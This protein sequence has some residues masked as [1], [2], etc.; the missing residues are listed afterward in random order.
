MEEEEEEKGEANRGLTRF[1]GFYEAVAFSVNIILS[2]ASLARVPLSLHYPYD[3]RR[4]NV[5]VPLLFP[6]PPDL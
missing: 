3:A 2:R 5:F 4:L 1:N 6:L